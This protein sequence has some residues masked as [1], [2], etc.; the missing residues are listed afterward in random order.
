MQTALK[1]VLVLLTLMTGCPE[2]KYWIKDNDKLVIPDNMMPSWIAVISSLE[3]LEKDYR[4]NYP[5]LFN[6]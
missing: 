6:D 2:Y 1:H 3:A 5:E 4:K